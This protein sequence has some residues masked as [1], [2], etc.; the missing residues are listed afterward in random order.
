[1][2]NTNLPLLKFTCDSRECDFECYINQNNHL[3]THYNPSMSALL[4][5]PCPDCKRGAL[6]YS[7]NNTKY[8]FSLTKIEKVAEERSQQA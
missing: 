6:R 1:M 8:E 3:L 5:W 2:K 7:S 4:D